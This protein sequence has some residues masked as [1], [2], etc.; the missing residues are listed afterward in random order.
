MLVA[1]FS[2]TVPVPP[3]VITGASLTAPRFIVTVTVLELNTPSEPLTVKVL[4]PFSLA[5]GT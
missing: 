2:A 5:P 3:D 1:A 4:A